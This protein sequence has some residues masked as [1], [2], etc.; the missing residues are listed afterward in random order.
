LASAARVQISVAPFW[1]A[2]AG[3]EEEDE[4]EEQVEVEVFPST[5]HRSVVVD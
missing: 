3:E 1:A 2:G 5:T 4:Y